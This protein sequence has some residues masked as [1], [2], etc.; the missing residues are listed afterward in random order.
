[1]IGVL[2]DEHEKELVEAYAT[3]GIEC[4]VLWEKDVLHRWN[5]IEFE[6]SEW[7]DKAVSDMNERPIYRKS[8]KAKVDKRKGSLGC[9]YGSGRVF[10]TKVALGKWMESSKNYWR[11]GLEEGRDYVVCGICSGR[12]AKLTEHL[13]KS[14]GVS[15]ADYL[16]DYPGSLLVAGVISDAVAESCRLNPRRSV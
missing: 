13:R 4:L 11:P 3:A 6:V 16:E 2:P 10:R 14:H 9:P 1:M 8:T 7:I 12:M 15:K 5:D